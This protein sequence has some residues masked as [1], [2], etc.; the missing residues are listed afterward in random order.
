MPK[1]IKPVITRGTVQGSCPKCAQPFTGEMNA[2][3]EHI[4]LQ[5][6]GCGHVGKYFYRWPDELPPVTLRHQNNRRLV[7]AT[8]AD[9]ERPSNA[10]NVLPGQLKLFKPKR[11][12]KREN[13]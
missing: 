13:A 6:V 5:C 9:H 4:Q 3:D 11:S 8:F 10:D 1:P 12:V 7:G 2:D